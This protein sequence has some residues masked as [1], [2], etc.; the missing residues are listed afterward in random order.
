MPEELIKLLAES[1]F[2]L[3][4]AYG[5]YRLAPILKVYCDQQIAQLKLIGEAVAALGTRLDEVEQRVDSRLVEIE[6]KVDDLA[7]I[8]EDLH[9]VR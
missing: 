4:L 7:E 5:V 2:A 6:H 1:P 9:R 8:A 3:A